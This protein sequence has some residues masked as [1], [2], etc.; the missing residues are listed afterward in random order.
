MRNHVVEGDALWPLSKDEN[1]PL[2]FI[3]QEAL[4]NRHEEVA[5]RHQHGDGNRHGGKLM[6]ERDLQGAIVNPQQP[7]EEALEQSP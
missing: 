7:I 4:G 3:R 6:S 2:I 1:L 5:S